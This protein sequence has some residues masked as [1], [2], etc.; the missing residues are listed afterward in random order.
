VNFY[1]LGES[2]NWG[3][4]KLFGGTYES[5]AIY[6]Q[7]ICASR[8]IFGKIFLNLGCQDL[9]TNVDTYCSCHAYFPVAQ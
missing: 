5:D 3:K 9:F 1:L 8:K 2:E 7:A 6:S 4:G